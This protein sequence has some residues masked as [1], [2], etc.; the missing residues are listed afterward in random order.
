[1]ATPAREWSVRVATSDDAEQLAK[2]HVA[3]WQVGYRGLLQ[4]EFLLALNPRNP[5]RVVRWRE[6]VRDG[7]VYVATI[8]DALIMGFIQF[9]PSR[10]AA[11]DARL[12]LQAIYVWPELWGLGVADKL[13]AQLPNVPTFL[14]VIAG[15]AR[16][17]RFYEKHGFTPD[18]GERT[19][20]I[21]DNVV[22]EVRYTREVRR[23]V[24]ARRKNGDK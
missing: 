8:N 2:V 5:A 6:R 22:F 19:R 7:S 16:A 4:H 24:Y 12:E 1:M 9:G 15:N 17:R 21:D 3:A 14:W 10:D 13:M 11:D 18:G 20:T 23:R